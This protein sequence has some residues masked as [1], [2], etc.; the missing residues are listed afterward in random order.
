MIDPAGTISAI[1][2][3]LSRGEITAAALLDQCLAAIEACDG[4]LH[5]MLALNSS[6]RAEAEAADRAITAGGYLGP[7]HGIPLVIKDNIDMAGLPTTSGC[8]GLREAIPYRDADQVARLRAAGA[9]IVGKTN[10]SEFS[11]EI[12]SRSSLGGDV[13]HPLDH[14]VTPGGSSGGTAV[15]ISAGFALAGLGTDT[16]GSIRV[17]AAYTGLVGFRP[18]HGVLSMRGIAPLAPST[19]TVGTMAR[20][21]EDVAI[22]LA[23]MGVET[24]PPPERPLRVGI[25]RQAF[26]PHAAIAA[27]A[28]QAIARLAAAGAVII[29]PVALNEGMLPLGGEHIV[30]AEFADAFDRY[31]AA[32]FISGTAPGSLAALI[33]SGAHLPEYREGLQSRLDRKGGSTRAILDSHRQLTEALAGLI[34]RERLDALLFPTSQVVPDSLDNPKGGWAPELAARSGWPALSV[35]SG[36]IVSRLP[37]GVELLGPPGHEPALFALARLVESAATL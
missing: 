27:A 16:G 18:A 4:R 5:A 35:P 6:A 15:A 3:R 22:L 23:A 24:G 12:R 9:I 10:L 20:S 34:A 1:A 7:L 8:V 11:F 33:A 31:L 2:P 25:L 21:V 37:V 32:N 36:G 28:G 17:P 19:D 13:L 30:D 26:G 29:D 14:R